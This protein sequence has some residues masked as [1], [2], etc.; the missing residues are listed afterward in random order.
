MT[1]V[2]ILLFGAASSYIAA[3]APQPSLEFAIL[4]QMN[5]VRSS[6]RAFD[7]TLQDYRRQFEGKVA[8]APGGAGGELT[9]EG[10]A[11][12]DEALRFL[13]TT[14]SSGP[15]QWDDALAQMA[16]EHAAD[17]GVTGE[18]GHEASDGSDFS[19]RVERHVRGRSVV[20]EIISYGEASH[21]DVVRQFIVDDG[22][23]SRA[24]RT[25]LFETGIRRAGVACRPHPVYTVSCVVELSSD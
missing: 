18:V 22:E 8:F 23:P 16:A 11:A 24:H 15:L 4:Q 9:Q 2:Q 19:E 1:A 5:L 13:D 3:A 10:P 6:P 25:D 17:Q 20:S 7:R 21:V 12:V 14:S